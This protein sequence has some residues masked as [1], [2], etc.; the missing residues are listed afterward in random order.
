[1]MIHD[2]GDGLLMQLDDADIKDIKESLGDLDRLYLP[3]HSSVVRFLIP[4]LKYIL[5]EAG[6]S[7]K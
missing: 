6:E 5:A 3:G 2:M 4:T 7:E 1:M